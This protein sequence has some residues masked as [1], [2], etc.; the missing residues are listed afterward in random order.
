VEAADGAELAVLVERLSQPNPASI[1]EAMLQRILQRHGA[2][3]QAGAPA[4]LLLELP[5]AA[6][7]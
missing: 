1:T 7:A 6:T 4:S 5:A 2:R 3:L